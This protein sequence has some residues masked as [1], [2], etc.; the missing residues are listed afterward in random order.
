[1]NSSALLSF[2]VDVMLTLLSCSEENLWYNY[3]LQS[4]R[5]VHDGSWS[6]K[7][8]SLSLINALKEQSESGSMSVRK[9]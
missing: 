4:L 3:S 8:V 2:S 1:M 6:T 5:G 9:Y 7:S